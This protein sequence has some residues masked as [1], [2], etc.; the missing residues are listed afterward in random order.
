MRRP[1]LR[2]AGAYACFLLLACVLLW[3]VV[4]RGEALLPLQ[5]A[6][7]FYPWKQA[8]EGLPQPGERL[9]GEPL[10]WNALLA[11]SV[12]Q[13][14]PWRHFAR[15]S[16]HAGYLPLWNP[17]QFCGTPFVAN[18]Q[19]ALFYP[20]NLL[21][22]VLPV[23][24]AF[25][26][27]AILHLFLAGAF[28]YLYLRGRGVDRGPALLGG[29]TFELSG[30]VVAWLELPTAV[31]VAVWLPLAFHLYERSRAGAGALRGL[32][33][34]IPLAMILLAG[35]PQFAFYA[36]LGF[37]LYALVHPPAGRE[38]AQTGLI[39][40]AGG[41]LG[42][43]LVC[44]GVPL[45]LAGLIAAAQVLLMLELSRLSHRAGGSL[46][47]LDASGYRNQALP[48][49]SAVV[50]AL[51]DF[52]GNPMRGD[53]WGPANRAEFVGYV[54]VLPLL[55]A[56]LMAVSLLVPSIRRPWL[57]AL[58]PGGARH[59][60]FFL[61]L[62]LV[63][64]A[65]SFRTPIGDVLYQ[66]V[67]G[68]GRLGS[69]GRMLYLFTVAL[70]MLAG[71]GAHALMRI[72]T[73]GKPVA[74]AAAVV[75][76]GGMSVWLLASLMAA[77]LGAGDVLGATAGAAF[78]FCA[79]LVLAGGVLAGSG[80]LP[81]PTAGALLLL[82]LVGDLLANAWGQNP[83]APAAL[84]YPPNPVVTVLKQD[85]EARFLAITPRWS[86]GEYPITVLPPNTATAV[87]LFDVNGYD[88]LYGIAYK[89]FLNR[90]A[91]KET[92][93]AANGNMIL[94]ESAE[95]EVLRALGCRYV[96]T[97]G[98]LGEEHFELLASGVVNVYRLRGACPRAFL[99]GGPGQATLSTM[100]PT[101]VMMSLDARGPGQVVLLESYF[102]GWRA[103]V[104][105]QPAPVE[106]AREVFRAVP[107]PAGA[108]RLELHYAP[109]SFRLG[110]F[111]TLLGVGFLTGAGIA[112]ASAKKKVLSPVE[113]APQ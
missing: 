94:F 109:M 68:L 43:L 15:E 53:F 77:A 63:A 38:S 42:G 54:G 57:A 27:S 110:L 102:P 104:D 45:A 22:W 7:S 69:P 96:V 103:W 70:A 89:S 66:I 36:L 48:L 74:L 59:V 1:S 26:V 58:P 24:H 21:F 88:S 92:S 14:L 81:R 71:F 17:H 2:D 113:R 4:L 106:L 107:V 25:G 44:A 6:A 111:L 98:P 64:V 30:F 78:H 9:N 86:L 82:V 40:R 91:G 29:I 5:Y 79:L 46:L 80:R 62:A 32:A 56:A 18:Y 13:Y 67:P 11:D 51:P 95:P 75:G 61:G 37:A 76:V 31:N 90:L 19:S 20:F 39:P 28:V 93:P 97:L 112:R 35:H 60:A 73:R 10:P 55:L 3:P 87:G 16:L 105:G 50:L 101:R 83:T 33:T 100:A 99:E 52:F 41:W 85:P 23:V 84:A 12:L 65:G 72:P 49:W 34:T 8:G 108:R 47:S